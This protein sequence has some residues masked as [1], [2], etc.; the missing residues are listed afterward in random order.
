MFK[1]LCVEKAENWWTSNNELLL[2][3]RQM[4]RLTNTL[5]AVT[6]THTVLTTVRW[7]STVLA[8]ICVHVVLMSSHSPFSTS[9]LS[10]LPSSS[11]LPPL[12]LLELLTSPPSPVSSH[13]SLSFSLYK[14]I[15]LLLSP[16]C[17]LLSTLPSLP[18]LSLS[19][20]LLS[21]ILILWYCFVSDVLWRPCVKCILK[22]LH[23][24]CLYWYR[25]QIKRSSS[26]NKNIQ[27]PSHSS[28]LLHADI[29]VRFCSLETELE[30]LCPYIV[31]NKM[32]CTVTWSIFSPLCISSPGSGISKSSEREETGHKG[33]PEKRCPHKLRTC[34]VKIL[35]VTAFRPKWAKSCF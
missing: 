5:L 35:H 30:S 18:L 2:Y 29:W 11:P 8:L 13:Q 19:S 24:G 1:C 20:D 16:P 4:E 17:S 25:C 15:I 7:Y 34:Y 6:H 32:L 12:F 26:K 27:P 22:M 3:T 31:C 21:A 10:P 9:S 28:T 33:V 23:V 14:I